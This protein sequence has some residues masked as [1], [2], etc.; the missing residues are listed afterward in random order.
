MTSVTV[1]LQDPFE[2]ENNVF[3][4]YNSGTS[5]TTPPSAT[6]YVPNGTSSKYRSTAGWSIFQKIQELSPTGIENVNNDMSA[7]VFD[8]RGNKVR[9]KATSLEGLPKGIY[10]INKRKVA[11]Q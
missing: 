2:I 7:D 8:L 5:E 1:H 10:I 3:E 6:L 9:S 4:I 11:V